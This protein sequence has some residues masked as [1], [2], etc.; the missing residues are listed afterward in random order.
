MRIALIQNKPG[1]NK[2][3]NLDNVLKLIPKDKFDI[4]IFSESFSSP[5]GINYFKEYSEN[6]E[7]GGMTINFL[8]DLSKSYPD[9][10]IIGGSFPEENNGKYYNTCTVWNNG[11]IITV[12]RK[13]HLFDVN[14]PDANNFIFRESDV[15]SPGNKP[16]FFNTPWG[17][18][19]L[20]I[21]FDLRFNK[22]SN[23]YKE[24][25]C[26]LIC[27][28][29]NFTKWSGNLHWKLL[30]RARAVDNQCFIIGCSNALNEDANY[31]AYGHSM[32]VDPWGKVLNE[33]SEEEGQSITNIN[34]EETEKM[35]KSIPLNNIL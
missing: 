26:K 1:N 12:Y 10:Y 11:K 29:G 17:N 18:I 7:M 27:Y 24:N 32:I 28:P 35:R 14:F 8:R 25:D 21:C 9:I 6:I 22:L 30:L 20:G 5:Y 16:V 13:M 33:L 31:H 15:L 3:N 34:I 23:Y 4:L 19:G 2:K